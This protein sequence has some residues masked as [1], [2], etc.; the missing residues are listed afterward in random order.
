MGQATGPLP[1]SGEQ[2]SLS[3][4]GDALSRPQTA[5]SDFLMGSSKDLA[6]HIRVVVSG[7][8]WQAGWVGPA[9]T[10]AASA[11]YIPYTLPWSCLQCDGTDLTPK[12]QDLKPQ[13]IV[14]LNIPR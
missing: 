10:E 13:C 4:D 1:G 11:P 9:G 2:K 12:I 7:P 14:F 3:P 5:F 8:S 6:K